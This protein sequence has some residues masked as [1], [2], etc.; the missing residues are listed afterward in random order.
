MNIAKTEDSKEQKSTIFGQLIKAKKQIKS[1]IKNGSAKLYGG[2]KY[3]EITDILEKVEP[4]LHDNGL[5]LIQ[6]PKIE[7]EIFQ[8][9]TILVNEAGE[10]FIIA[11]MECDLTK[12]HSKD[13]NPQ[14]LGKLITYYRKYSLLAGLCLGT[15][16][17]D[18]QDIAKNQYTKP[19]TIA[20]LPK[21]KLSISRDS[22]SPA[23]DQLAAILENG[24]INGIQLRG[25]YMDK[26]LQYIL[27]NDE[28]NI[29]TA[30]A[31]FLTQGKVT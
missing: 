7:R 31:Y 18:C 9:T 1:I 12:L 11:D 17:D 4:A 16:D 26:A 29:A 2:Y 13:F 25:D 6:I 10:Q 27:N 3:V 5:I 24:E 14:D 15:S 23:G 22:L 30:L 21:A 28:Q 8:L 19:K 20:P